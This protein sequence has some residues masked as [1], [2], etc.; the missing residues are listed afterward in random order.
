MA[1]AKHIILVGAGGC[2][3]ELAW[4]IQERNR[5]DM[6]WQIDGYVDVKKP[7]TDE[8]CIVGKEVIPYLGNDDYLLRK[9]EPV[10]VAICVGNPTLRKKI[11][12]RLKKNVNIQFPNLI[13]GDTRICDD[14]KM[15]EGCIISMDCKVSTNVRFGNF[16]F[17]NIGSQVCHDGQLGDFVT[18]SP[19]VKLAGNVQ[20]GCTCDIGLG[21]KV[22]QGITIGKGAVIGAGGVVVRDIEA[23][24]TAVGV[25]ARSMIKV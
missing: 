4:Q 3:R 5:V 12:E 9:Q 10:N 19:D 17:L 16:V 23:G 7:E 8:Q 1:E 25:P 11:A 6:I 15:G 2:M 13:L 14:V 24:C 20:V 21:V 18:L 22:I